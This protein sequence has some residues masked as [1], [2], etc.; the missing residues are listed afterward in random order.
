MLF[1]PH[2]L[3]EYALLADGERGALVGPRGDIAFMCAP[4]WHDDAVFSALLGGGGCYAV[5]PLD[6]RFVWGGYYEPDTLIWRGR[7]VTTDAVVESRE[8]LAFPGE[9][10]RLVLLR[11]VEGHWGQTRVRVALECRAGF[12]EQPMTVR[13]HG[14]VWEG[15]TG[16]LRLRWSGAAEARLEDGELVLDLTVSA[17]RHHDLVLELSDAAL[18]D[19]VPDPDR[20]WAATERAWAGAVPR[21]DGSAAPGDARHSYAVLRGL[22]SSTGAMVAA[23]TTALPERAEQGRNYDYR[24]AWIRD[25][26][27]AGQAAA[28]VG[29]H[30]LLDAAVRFVTE[31]VHDDGAR[32]LPAYTVTGERVPDERRLTLPGYPGAPTQVGNHAGEQFQ[33][34]AF[35]ESLLLL[36]SADRAGRLDAD[37]WRAVE[38]LVD[39]I[40][41]RGDEPDG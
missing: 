19:E 35:G 18:P 24:Y 41:K 21:L 40:E 34:D 8:A 3:R 11:R 31:R 17:G 10:G 1:P 30:D 2:T 25:Q 14:D 32:L 5:T 15:S 9:T 4:R 23:A 37:G 27:F 12:G 6:P 39:A 33:L 16:A 29:G 36:A 7:L 22:T 20:V 26:C 13:R 28:V 38:T